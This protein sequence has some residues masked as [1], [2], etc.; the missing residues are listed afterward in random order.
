MTFESTCHYIP[1][2]LEK[3]IPFNDGEE[4]ELQDARAQLGSP[5]RYGIR[6][7]SAQGPWIGGGFVVTWRYPGPGLQ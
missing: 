3:P 6:E 1:K 4:N 2:A 5:C 7:Q